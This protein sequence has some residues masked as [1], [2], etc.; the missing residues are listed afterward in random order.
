M[1]TKRITNDLVADVTNKCRANFRSFGDGRY[2]PTN[3]ISAALADERPNFAAGVDIEE[4][5]LFVINSIR[6]K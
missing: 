2:D 1:K 6:D 3:P 4:V 5:V